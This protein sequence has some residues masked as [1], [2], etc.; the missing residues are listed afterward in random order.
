MQFVAKWG[1]AKR[2]AV[3]LFEEESQLLKRNIPAAYLYHDHLEPHNH[4]YYF[5]EFMER[6]EAV[7]LQYLSEENVAQMLLDN[8]SQ[9]VTDALRPLSLIQQEQ[10]MDFLRGRRF[11]QTL[12]CHKEIS[13]N[14]SLRSDQMM[15]FHVSLRTLPDPVE[16]D[17]RNDEPS[18][19]KSKDYTMS[20]KKRVVKA[21]IMH[22]RE[23]YPNYVHFSELH[24]EAVNRLRLARD[25]DRYDEL[26]DPRALSTDL[27]IGLCRDV[28]KIC[29]HP[30]RCVTRLSARPM[31]GRLSRVQASMGRSVT[32]QFH[33]PVDLDE[34]GRQI[35]RRLDGRHDRKALAESMQEAVASGR[36]RVD[37][38]EKA[39]PAALSNAV[40]EALSRICSLS[41]LVG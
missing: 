30:P 8:C 31:V 35:I 33:V 4:P 9:E 17:I 36:I 26:T 10:Y 27:M 1:D 40:D 34:F 21:A 41:L 2:L 11:R 5:H 37:N 24:E 7:G 25:D 18:K 29:V 28:F 38:A 3:K 39:G 13:L 12:L 16:V 14:R 15:C 6:A 19:F 22:L 23:I 32:N 20:I